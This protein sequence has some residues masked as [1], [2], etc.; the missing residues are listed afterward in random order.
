MCLGLS[1]LDECLGVVFG[2]C[3]EVGVAVE[4]FANFDPAREDGVE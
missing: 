3:T 4:Y 1:C 2:S